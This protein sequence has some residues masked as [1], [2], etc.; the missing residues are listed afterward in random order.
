MAK[1][2]YVV[3]IEA[4]IV[5]LAESED[6]AEKLAKKAKRDV[7]DWDYRGKAMSHMPS[8]WE[9]DCVPFGLSEDSD[10]ARDID[11]WVEAGAAPEY[12]ALRAKLKALREQ[13]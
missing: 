3:S 10:P 9:G 4:E 6:Q 5:V 11:G 1:Q 7:D 12:A 8:G 2:L 13:K